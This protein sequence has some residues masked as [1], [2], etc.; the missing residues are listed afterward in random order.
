MEEECPAQRNACEFAQTSYDEGSGL[1]VDSKMVADVVKE[2]FA[3]MRRLQV[4]YEF[5][6][7]YLDESGLKPTGTR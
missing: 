2:E 6:R 5:L 4:Q 7:G 1:P 3:F